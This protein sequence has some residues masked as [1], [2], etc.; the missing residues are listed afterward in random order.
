MLASMLG[1]GNPQL[2]LVKLQTGT[3]TLE[4]TQK[5]KSKEGL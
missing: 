1:Q 2:L 3:A 4:D 5:I